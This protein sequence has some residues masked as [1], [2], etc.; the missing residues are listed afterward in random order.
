M[1][2]CDVTPKQLSAFIFQ[3]DFTFWE[4]SARGKSAESFRRIFIMGPSNDVGA[5]AAAG[6]W[7]RG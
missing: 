4:R 5:E 6:L 7:W 3:T 1:G 2:L